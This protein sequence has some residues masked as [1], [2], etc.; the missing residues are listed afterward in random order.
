MSLNSPKILLNIEHQKLFFYFDS[1]NQKKTYLWVKK[2]NFKI[3]RMSNSLIIYDQ[4]LRSFNFCE[5][6]T[7]YQAPKVFFI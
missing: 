7:G 3:V 5:N 2:S 1:K 4:K 6:F